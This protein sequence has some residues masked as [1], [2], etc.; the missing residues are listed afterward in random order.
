MRNRYAMLNLRRGTRDMLAGIV[1]L[2]TVLAIAA[3]LST[4][5]TPPYLGAQRATTAQCGPSA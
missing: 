1:L 3:A 4:R 2:A 5:T